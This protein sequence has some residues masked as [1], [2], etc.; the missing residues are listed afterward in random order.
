[1]KIEN[2]EVTTERNYLDLVT[3]VPVEAKGDASHKLC[4]LGVIIR[5][6]YEHVKVLNCSTRTVQA[7]DPKYLVWG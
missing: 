5:T 7:C 1:M 2:R 3:F 6:K 4:S